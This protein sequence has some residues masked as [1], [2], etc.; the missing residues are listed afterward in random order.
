V[1]TVRV[2]AVSCR[3]PIVP[4]VLEAMQ[5][6]SVLQQAAAAGAIGE[7]LLH[8]AIEDAVLLWETLDTETIDLA[9]LIADVCAQLLQSEQL[10][11]CSK[12]ARRC[13][14]RQSV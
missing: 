8:V 10:Q 4:V 2:A 9:R 11:V 1:W 13:C 14:T 7:V 6:G 3:A 12:R 5:R